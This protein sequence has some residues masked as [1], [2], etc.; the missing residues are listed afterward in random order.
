MENISHPLLFVPSSEPSSGGY[1]FSHTLFP[2]PSIRSIAGR[3]RGDSHPYPRQTISREWVI[4]QRP[5]QP[6]VPYTRTACIIPEP[7][8][9][10][11][12]H[13]AAPSEIPFRGSSSFFLRSSAALRET[14]FLFNPVNPVRKMRSFQHSVTSL[15]LRAREEGR[16][17]RTS[18]VS[19]LCV[20][21]ALG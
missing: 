17:A 9:A 1:G 15:A 12:P 11:C 13:R 7:G 8:R 6:S 3:I 10:R 20:L 16:E 5:I 21:C 18:I 19:N 2:Y 14:I 4:S